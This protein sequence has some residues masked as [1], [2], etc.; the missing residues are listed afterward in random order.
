MLAEELWNIQVRW[1]PLTD[2]AAV[3]PEPGIGYTL[4]GDKVFGYEPLFPYRYDL[5]EAWFE[6]T[7]MPF[8]FAAWVARQGTDRITVERLE[9]ALRYG[10][11]HIPQ[12]AA[13]DRQAGGRLVSY[14]TAVE[15]LTRNID[16]TLD[17]PKRE[18][19]NLFWQ[20]FRKGYR[21]L[22]PG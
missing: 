2:F 10:A 14:E 21:R 12:A 16:F 17:G 6:L 20:K 11:A 9:E 18:S 8:V 4:I 7:G 3:T 13:W 5:A 15:Y 19:M 1:L 22:H